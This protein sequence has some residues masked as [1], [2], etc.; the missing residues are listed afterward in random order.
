MLKLLWKTMLVSP[1]FVG[2]A[3]TISPSATAAEGVP[4]S[5]FTQSATQ[6]VEIAQAQDELLE[7]LENYSQEG[8]LNSND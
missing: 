2:I 7:K 5:Q 4:G 3:L 6:G 1:A 8:Q